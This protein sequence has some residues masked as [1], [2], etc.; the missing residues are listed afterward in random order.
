MGLAPPDK[1]PLVRSIPRTPMQTSEMYVPCRCVPLGALGCRCGCGPRLAQL[2]VSGAAS[3]RDFVSG[4]FVA[5][6]FQPVTSLLPP[7]TKP[8]THR[9]APPLE[10][11]GSS[12]SVGSVSRRP[13]NP[14]GKVSFQR[15][16]SGRKQ[17]RMPSGMSSFGAGQINAIAEQSDDGSTV[18]SPVVGSSPGSMVREGFVGGAHG[19]DDDG[20]SDEDAENEIQVRACVRVRHMASTAWPSTHERQDAYFEVFGVHDED[21]HGR[22]LTEEELAAA[23]R[24]WYKP[25][26]EGGEG[27]THNT[28]NHASPGRVHGAPVARSSPLARKAAGKEHATRGVSPVNIRS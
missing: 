6:A 4:K 28:R 25:K 14:R 3:Y 8:A 24:W 5:E 2:Y 27:S 23:P 12:R 11:G 9:T 17:F 1:P 18:Y 21:V 15:R 16:A 7:A 10:L 26:N 19:S 13:G 20:T 22:E